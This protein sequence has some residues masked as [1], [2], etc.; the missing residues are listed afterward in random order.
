MQCIR[1]WFGMFCHARREGHVRT[2]LCVLRSRSSMRL[3]CLKGTAAWKEPSLCTLTTE[4]RRIC[5]SQST[6]WNSGP[7]YTVYTEYIPGSMDGIS[8]EDQWFISAFMWC[9]QL[10]FDTRLF[11][12]FFWHSFS[13][14][15]YCNCR[16]RVPVEDQWNFTRGSMVHKCTGKMLLCGTG[17]VHRRKHCCPFLISSCQ[18]SSISKI[19]NVL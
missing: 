1:D 11:E 2:C 17:T 10:Q 16:P 14:L 12:F 13:D 4:I 7:V 5:D 18:C 19:L 8:L 15:E 9:Q 3:H 6:K